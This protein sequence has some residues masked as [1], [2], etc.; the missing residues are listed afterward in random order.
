MSKPTC[1]GMVSL[2]SRELL[3]ESEYLFAGEENRQRGVGANSVRP[4]KQIFG[5]IGNL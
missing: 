4:C 2:A 5:R 1:N 3:I